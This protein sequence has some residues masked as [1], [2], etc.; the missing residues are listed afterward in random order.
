MK[1][2]ANLLGT[3]TLL[4]DEEDNINGAIPSDFI[5]KFF[6]DN[7]KYKDTTTICITHKFSKY[8]IPISF[9]Q[10]IDY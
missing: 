9:I 2:Y 8:V 10:V 6:I 4:D 5:L 1:I 7:E 3:W